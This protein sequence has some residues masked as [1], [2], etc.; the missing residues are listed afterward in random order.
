MP[1]CGYASSAEL[2]VQHR[3]IVLVKQSERI[4]ADGKRRVIEGRTASNLYSSA[5]SDCFGDVRF[6]EFK[7]ALQVALNRFHLT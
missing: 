3:V 5:P 6:G 2:A 4:K 7:F 1:T